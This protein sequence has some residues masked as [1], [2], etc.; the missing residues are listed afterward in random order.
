MLRARQ[1][2]WLSSGPVASD[3]NK[4][5]YFTTTKFTRVTKPIATS[6]PNGVPHYHNYHTR[7]QRALHRIATSRTSRSN[8]QLGLT[9]WNGWISFSRPSLLITRR[10]A[11]R[12]EPTEWPTGEFSQL[13]ARDSCCILTPRDA[14]ARANLSVRDSPGFPRIV[15]TSHKLLELR[16]SYPGYPEASTEIW[17]D[18]LPGRDP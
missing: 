4:S 12:M 3:L 6:L 16:Q 18:A 10:I 8:H 1:W 7:T 14:S 13:R 11:P 17:L 5:L 15:A 9:G 2:C